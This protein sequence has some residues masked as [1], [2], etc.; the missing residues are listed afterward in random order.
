MRGPLLISIIA[1]LLGCSSPKGDVL[2]V[3]AATS[4][5]DAFEAL[6][7]SFEESHPGA[8]VKLHFAGSQVLRLQIEHGAPADVYASANVAHVDALRAQGRMGSSTVIAYNTLTL[9]TPH[10]AA[11]HLAT[12]ADL[13]R[14]RRLVVGTPQT[15]VGRYAR[16]MLQKADQHMGPGFAQKV[17]SRVVSH[18]TNTR[19]VRAKVALGEADAAIVYATDV[20]GFDGV[21]AV[22]IPPTINIRAAYEMGVVTDTAQKDLA[23][24]WM[25]FVAGPTGRSTL[26]FH[27]FAQP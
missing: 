26:S 10:E 11:P 25:T 22:S 8:R 5:T 14:A 19:L 23:T 12:F 16:E 6:A 18:E 21:R 2:D 4:L 20:L 3:Y 1:A 15:P 13:P 7:R 9:I 27:G 24:R 17:A